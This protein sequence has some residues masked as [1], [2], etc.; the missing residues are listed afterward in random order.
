MGLQY[1]LTDLGQQ[2][3]AGKTVTVDSTK[4][5][6][7]RH[8]VSKKTGHPAVEGFE[9]E[10]FRLWYDAELDRIAPIADNTFHADGFSP[11]LITFNCFAKK[12]MDDGMSMIVGEKVI[13]GKRYV[14]ST[15]DF[16]MENPVA[17][18]F[19]KTLLE[20]P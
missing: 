11:I 7:P 16:R 14:L 9:K 18:R 13:D 15:L 10:D 8:F 5:Y 12:T 3:I 20:L 1:F 4:W 2:T 6:N 17:K 19:M